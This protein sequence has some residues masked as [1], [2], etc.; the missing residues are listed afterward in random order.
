M[1]YS[2]RNWCAERVVEGSAGLVTLETLSGGASDLSY[3]TDFL[4]AYRAGML[5]V[6]FGS[7]DFVG[8]YE[9]A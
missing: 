7:E 9:T 6:A 1:R 3:H 5:P 2:G 4:S 8:G